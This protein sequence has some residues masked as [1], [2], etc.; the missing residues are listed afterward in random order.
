MN[1]DLGAF[2]ETNFTKGIYTRE[3]SGY[4][5]MSLEAPSAHSGGITVLYRAAEHFS[6]EEMFFGA[7]VASFQL[8]SGGQ[9][10]YIMEC[11]LAP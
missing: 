3:Y 7:N 10:W 6:V 1:V 8:A 4:L 11:Y 5:V 2:Q 9:R